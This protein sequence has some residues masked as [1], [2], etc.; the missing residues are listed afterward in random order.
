MQVTDESSV[1]ITVFDAVS[2]NGSSNNARIGCLP[3]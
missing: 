3:P 1:N 2:P